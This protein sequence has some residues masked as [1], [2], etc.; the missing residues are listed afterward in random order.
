MEPIMVP[1]VCLLLTS[2][3]VMIL[4]YRFVGTSSGFESLM[5]SQSVGVRFMTTTV[6]VIIKLYWT[7]LKK[8]SYQEFRI[9]LC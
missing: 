3:G 7:L 2:L 4:Y 5:D 1:S 9:E 8:V 6:G